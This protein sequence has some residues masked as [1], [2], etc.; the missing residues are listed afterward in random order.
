MAA[1][2]KWSP[3]DPNDIR[4]YYFDWGSD[5]L[6]EAARFLPAGVT[7]TDS[8]VTMPVGISYTVTDHDDKRVRFRANNDAVVGKYAITNLI[9]VST[10]EQFESTKILEVKERVT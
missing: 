2:K 7:I 1:V 9:T 3:K 5:D 10:G 8:T 4:D 6:A